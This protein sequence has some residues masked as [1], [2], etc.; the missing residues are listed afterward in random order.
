MNKKLTIFSDIF[1]WL[2]RAKGLIYNSQNG[3]YLLFRPTSEIEN[4][5]KHLNDFDNLYSII[6]DDENLEPE[7]EKFI[8]DI[9]VRHFGI[10]TDV[11]TTIVSLPPLLNILNDIERLKHD[12][13]RSEG[14]NILKYFSELTVYTG[15]KC[16][17]NNYYRQT[18]YPYCSNKILKAKEIVNFIKTIESPYLNNINI[19][20]SDI[21]NY[22]DLH[23]LIDYL[24]SLTIPATMYFYYSE[25]AANK[26]IID[27]LSTANY[28]IKIVCEIDD[29]LEN[30][31]RQCANMEYQYNFLIKSEAEYKI[32][33]QIIA[34][35][36]IENY[37]VVPVF[38]ENLQF[39]EN[40]VF[41]NETDIMETKLSKREIF[42]HQAVNINFFGAFTVLPDGKVYSNPNFE[43]VG[44]IK[45]SVY[46]L[47]FNEI[48]KNYAWRLIRNEKPC[49]NC[50]FQWLCPSP[51][52]YEMII[53]K[54]NLCNIL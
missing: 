40:N 18:F 39:F 46:D 11:E 34:D 52:N 3:N 7:T 12:K 4:I 27:K 43:P 21:S 6:I 49:I 51:S 29:N 35:L 14:E 42:A 24:K 36:R 44:I 41:L 32:C 9:A 22:P 33:E 45:D 25:L 37:T 26:N 30:I 48:H 1:I 15:G 5:C 16:R 47:I 20:F 50:L 54:M 28:R 23:I 19:V 10:L 13:S 53:G 31:L 38:D 17:N 2:K 8:H